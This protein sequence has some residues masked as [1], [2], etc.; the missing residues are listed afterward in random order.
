MHVCLQAQRARDQRRMQARW[1][2]PGQELAVVTNV[3]TSDGECSRL[4]S[5]RSDLST[6]LHIDERVRA[7]KPV[8]SWLFR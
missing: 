3:N 5:A 6:E 2:G 4:T 8:T 7:W 1:G